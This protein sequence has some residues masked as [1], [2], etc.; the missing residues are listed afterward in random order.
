LPQ[1]KDLTGQRFGRL[2]VKHRGGS[3]RKSDWLCQCDC[4][5][6]CV[7]IGENLH[8]GNT[9]SCGC[10]RK[11]ALRT[12]K[13]LSSKKLYDLANAKVGW[14]TVVERAG[15]SSNGEALWRCECVCGT[16]G[17]VRSSQLKMRKS[18]SCGCARGQW[19]RKQ[20]RA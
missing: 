15:S 2:T 12:N 5:N 3:A 19:V 4:G 14:W 17:M 10:L 6:E 18:F 7:V 11:E 9:R 20:R 16:K 13:D 1:I 8:S